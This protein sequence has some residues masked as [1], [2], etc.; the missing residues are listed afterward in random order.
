MNTRAIAAKVLVPVINGETTITEA[1]EAPAD[2]VPA[3]EKKLLFELCL[4]TLRYF[5]RLQEISQQLMAKPL[6]QKDSD[7]QAL[8]ALGLYQLIYLRVPDHAAISETV[9]AAREFGK[10]WATKLINGVLRNYLRQQREI[11]TK[12]QHNDC[13]QYSHPAWLIDKLQTA[14]P[15]QWQDILT[16]NNQQAPLTLRVN[17]KKI[18]IS[19][20]CRL[21]E[22]HNIAHQR[23]YYSSAGVQLVGNTEVTTLPGYHDGLFS[24]QDE[25]AQLSAHLLSLTPR[26]RILDACC[27]PGGKSGHILEAQPHLGELVSIDSDADRMCRVQQNFERLGHN[28]T[29]IVADA[30]VTNSWW[31]GHK[32]D[33]ILVDA[34]CSGT[35]TIRRHPD[36]KLLRRV[37]DLAKLVKTQSELITKLWATL[38]PGGVMVYATC[39]ILPE[40]NEEIVRAFCG[41]HPDA[42]HDPIAA[43]WGVARPYGRQLFPQANGHDG[44]YYA[45][46]IKSH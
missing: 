22:Q 1:L 31:D 15:Q 18:S 46:I 45:R 9:G 20:Y 34:P 16:T 11:A 7:V 43:N 29:L 17:C 23:L 12:L 4:G 3:T 40:E 32:F 44:F 35:G 38:K 10:E 36:I 13:F 24:V 2:T 21:L 14:W 27:A 19:A 5:H 30:A 28:A 37:A 8:I 41:R 26:E 39:S 25:A 33:G 42:I 6:R